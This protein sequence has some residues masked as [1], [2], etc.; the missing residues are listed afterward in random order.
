MGE[1][2][3]MKGGG[4]ERNYRD[5]RYNFFKS[6]VIKAKINILEKKRWLFLKNVNFEIVHIHFYKKGKNI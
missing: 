1:E 6:P 3:L 2:G 4:V 5:A